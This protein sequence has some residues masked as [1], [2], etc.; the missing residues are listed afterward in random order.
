MENTFTRMDTKVVKGAAILLMLAHHLFYSENRMLLTMPE[1]RWTLP[2]HI[3]GMSLEQTAAGFGK[4]CVAV[5]FFLAGYGLYHQMQKATFRLEKKIVTLYRQYWRVFFIFIPIGFLFFRHQPDYFKSTEFCHVFENFRIQ[6]VIAA[7]LCWS[8]PYNQEWGFLSAYLVSIAAGCVYVRLTEKHRPAGFWGELFLV[9]GLSYAVYGLQFLP[10]YG[11]FSKALVM[12]FPRGLDTGCAV[13]MGILFARYRVLDRW[14]AR[15]QTACTK[16]GAALAAAGVLV[17]LVYLRCAVIGGE[18]DILFAPLFAAAVAALL[19]LAP[20][21][22][23]LLAFFGKYSMNI[24]LIHT[25]YAYYYYP[26]VRLTH[27][28]G[29]LWVDY[30]IL[31]ALSAASAILVDRV[32]SSRP[33]ARAAALFCRQA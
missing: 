11:F 4:I 25:F 1:I 32:W 12:I 6:D 16:A 15:S 8:S 3:A 10:Q 28:S 26:A 20:P 2:G 27:C 30:L 22:Y 13:F 7:A 5:F 14:M 23:K 33:A 18:G 21:L 24:W 9:L 19:R 17:C 31:L 29:L